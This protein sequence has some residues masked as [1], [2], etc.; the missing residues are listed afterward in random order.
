[1]LSA[2]M[3]KISISFLIE[4]MSKMVIRFEG[5][6]TDAAGVNVYTY[7]KAE[8]AKVRWRMS[9]LKTGDPP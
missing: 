8:S 4:A 7:E 6:V 5:K 9:I 1:M 2:L 3:I